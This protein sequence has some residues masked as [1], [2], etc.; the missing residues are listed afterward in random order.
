MYVT[1]Q[2]Y[3]Y[4]LQTSGYHWGEGSRKGQDRGL[5]LSTNYYV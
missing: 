2:T 1:K 3:R 4:K 5:Q